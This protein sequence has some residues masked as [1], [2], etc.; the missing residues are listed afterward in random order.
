LRTTFLLLLTTLTACGSDAPAEAPTPS[1][2]APAKKAPADEP[3]LLVS[4][5]ISAPAELPDAAAVFVSLRTPGR[6]GPPLAAKKLPVGP[7]PMDFTITSADR[8]M[9]NGPVPDSFEVKVTLDIDG[10][11]MAKSPD[12]LEAVVTGTLAQKGLAVKLQ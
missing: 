3:E 4:G 8:P 2:E 12:D 7:F 9:V 11:P 5:T 6:R 1:P 10:N